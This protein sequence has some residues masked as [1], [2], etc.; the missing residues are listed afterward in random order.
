MIIEN[1]EYRKQIKLESLFDAN[2]NTNNL[3]IDFIFTWLY[4][5]SYSYQIQIICKYLTHRWDPS[6]YSHS[7]SEW[8]WE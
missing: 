1:E 2:E 3:Q 4:D 5:I 6:R 8:N 7:E